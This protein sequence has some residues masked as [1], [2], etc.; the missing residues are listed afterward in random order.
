MP[1]DEGFTIKVD[2]IEVEKEKVLDCLLSIK[3][4]PGKHVIEINYMPRGF[5]TGSIVSIIG[6]IVL[7]VL[8]ILERRRIEKL[9]RGE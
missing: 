7:I 8:Y 2:G 4:T 9:L 1:Y 6:L 3:I 5:I